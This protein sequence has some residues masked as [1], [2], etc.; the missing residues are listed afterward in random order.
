MRRDVYVYKNSCCVQSDMICIMR[1]VKGKSNVYDVLCIVYW[2]GVLCNKPYLVI[3]KDYLF[4]IYVCM[5]F[6]SIQT[7]K[8]KSNQSGVEIKKEIE[9][10]E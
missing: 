4:R 5:Q 8:I 2:L 7:L 9:I 10:G 3:A 6:N 1:N